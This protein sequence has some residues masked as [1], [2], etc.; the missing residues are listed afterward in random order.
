LLSGISVICFASSYSVA[1]ALEALRSIFRMRVRAA[2]AIAFAA[3]GF[4]AQT[5]YL[6]HRAASSSSLPLSSAYEWFLLAAW[7]L[8][9]VYLYLAFQPALSAIGVFLL[10]LALALIAAAH[11]ASHKTVPFTPAK[12]VWGV[13]HG[14]LLLAG[15]VSVMVG[16]V[17][18]VA[19]LWQSSRLK[20]KRPP[21]TGMLLPSLERLEHV[22]RRAIV[23]SALLVGA[24]VLSAFV[25]NLIYHRQAGERSVPWTDPIVWRSAGMFAWLL[26]AVTFT[27]VYRP[28]R[29]GRKVAYLTVA[30]FVFLAIFLLAQLLSTGHEFGAQ[31]SAATSTREGRV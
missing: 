5:L 21:P 25:L 1:F 17:A 3:A 18:G 15:A 11:Y 7:A 9:A 14:V 2:L 23:L 28:A 8:V 10:P 31:S 6:G 20:H 16:F 29:R 13:I 4:V 27:T 24:G 12:Q 19:Y 22:N 26:A 30:S